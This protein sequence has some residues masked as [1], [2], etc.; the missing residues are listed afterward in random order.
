MLDHKQ[1]RD[2]QDTVRIET[3]HH[4]FECSYFEEGSGEPVTLFVHGLPTWSFLFRNAY[5]A[6]DHAIIPD[7]VSYGYTKHL[8]P[9]GY[10]RDMK[11]QEQF[12]TNFLDKLGLDTVQIVAHD[13]GGGAALRFAVHNPDRVE[14]L[15]LSNCPL[16][17][18]FPGSEEFHMRGL[19]YVAREWTR[20]DLDEILE[21]I[22]GDGTYKEERATKE[23][24]EGMKAP[25]LERDRPLTDLSRIAT[26]LNT[27]EAEE[28]AHLYDTVDCPTML[29]WGDDDV[30]LPSKWADKL[31]EDMPNVQEKVYLD[32]AYH[33]LMQDR[34]NAYREAIERFMS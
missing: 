16:Y 29:L 15:V 14:R 5:D 7:L 32:R 1:W 3:D 26:T 27:N 28:I 23:F 8:G 33:W 20:E 31:A 4:E 9:G 11:V 24:V 21:S 13:M 6:V 18:N 10:D 17:D 2:K 30:L 19:P 34:P 22:F 12:L 25:F